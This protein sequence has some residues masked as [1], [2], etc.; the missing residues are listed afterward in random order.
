MR[1]SLLAHALDFSSGETRGSGQRDMLAAAGGTIFGRYFQNA[2]DIN[3]KGYI[4]LR[5]AAWGRGDAI[6]NEPAE[7][8]VVRRQR[9]LT[10]HDV[11]LHLWLII[12]SR[13]KNLALAGG[14]G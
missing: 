4:D 11:D 7:G 13:G 5:D 14:N 8:F 6:Q 10:L 9:A 12:A 3:I 1:F 2:I